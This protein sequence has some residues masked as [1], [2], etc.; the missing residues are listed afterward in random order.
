VRCGQTPKEPAY[1]TEEL[2][3]KFAKLQEEKEL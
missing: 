3:K 1:N 2:V